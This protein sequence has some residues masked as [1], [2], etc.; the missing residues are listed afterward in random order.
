MS[1][2]GIPPRSR[3]G[4]AKAPLPT[5]PST[6]ETPGRSGSGAPPPLPAPRVGALVKNF[7]GNSSS[8]NHGGSHS[9]TPAKPSGPPP[10]LPSGPRP[11]VQQ[12]TQSHQEPSPTSVRPSPT[13]RTAS[14]PSVPPERPSL[15]RGGSGGAPPALPPERPQPHVP[16]S[17]A[18]AA[19]ERPQP[20][21][22]TSD[23]EGF[24]SCLQNCY[25]TITKRHEDELL[26]LESLRGHVFNRARLD[27]EYAENLAKT[28]A[29][30]SRKM[31]NVSNKSS[32]IVQVSGMQNIWNSLRE[33]GGGRERGR[34]KCW[35]IYYVM[36]YCSSF[37][38][39]LDLRKF[40]KLVACFFMYGIG[41]QLP[42]Y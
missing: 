11:S 3:P 10:P 20:R 31:S 15:P 38:Y 5:P 30:A 14:I 12:L 4:G 32:A 34:I 22:S 41:L 19:P 39:C 21:A 40:D 1:G 26:A 27:K 6:P 23:G 37:R 24:G 25:E 17:V 33:G 16:A 2:P 35:S 13:P 18:A 36:F 29:K 9:A 8:V 28:N 42:Y 7:G